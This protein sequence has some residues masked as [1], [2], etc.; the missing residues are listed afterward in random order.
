MNSLMEP[1]APRVCTRETSQPTVPLDSL[2]LRILRL[3]EILSQK[4]HFKYQKEFGYRFVEAV[5]LHD[6]DML[7]ALWA[8]QSGK[9]QL[10]ADILAACCLI[11]PLLARMKIFEDDWRLNCTDE[12]GNYRGYKYGVVVGIYAPKQ[13][14][15]DIVY[16][17]LR[18]TLETDTTKEVAAE[19]N[20]ALDIGNANKTRLSN[21]SR[22]R[23]Q[24]ASEQSHIEGDTYHILILDEAQDIGT[25]KVRKCFAEGTL[26]ITSGG[27]EVPVEEVVKKKLPVLTP[28][29]F[30]ESRDIEYHDNGV[31]PV[32]RVTL[33]GGRY[34]DVTA[35]HRHFVRSR[36]RRVPFEALTYEIQPGWQM[37]VPTRLNNAAGVLGN[38][39]RG[40][41]LGLLLGD[42]CF[43]GDKPQ[44]I[45]E[46][47][48][49]KL[50]DRIC[51]HEF[52]VRPVVY[53][54]Q[55]SGMLECGLTSP[56]NKKGSNK[57]TE[58][59]KKIGVWGAKRENK[60]IPNLPWSLEFL[61]G[62]AS[63]LIIADG[64]IE[65][66]TVKPVVSFSNCSEY[67][68]DGLRKT[69]L[70]FG[71]QCAKFEGFVESTGN[72][73]GIK[74]RLGTYMYR[75]HIKSV[76]D[77]REFHKQFNLGPKQDALEAGIRTIQGKRGRS[78]SQFYPED[79]QFVSVKSVRHIGK[80]PTYCVTVPDER[81][82]V[83]ANGIVTGNS[84]H[85]MVAAY[86]GVI[87]KIGTCSTEK[88]DFYTSIKSNQRLYAQGEA[89][90][91][92]RYDYLVCQ[93]YNSMYR[94]YI[95]KEKVR[96][97]EDS[98]EFRL[99]YCCEWLLERGQFITDKQL[100]TPAIA[101]THGGYHEIWHRSSRVTT[102][103][104]GIDFGKI[105]DPSVITVMDVDWRTPVADEWV[106]T[107][108][109]S[110]HWI[111]YNKRVVAWHMLLGD[112]YEHQFHEIVNF[113]SNFK[114]L[115]KITLDA[116][117]V[118]EWGLDKFTVYYSEF[119]RGKGADGTPEMGFVE[120]QGVKFTPASKSDGF[121]ILHSDLMSGR[122]SFPAGEKA[123]K[124]RHFRRFVGE[125]LDL[126]K[127]YKNN[128][129][130][131]E[132]P[133]EP[134][135]HDD[136]PV[137]LMLAAYGAQEPAD[138]GEIEVQQNFMVG[139]GVIA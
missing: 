10:I 100:M 74:E 57:L 109:G 118:G 54:E 45:V 127:L 38:F 86:N 33:A 69:L 110:F 8:R 51:P 129:M 40:F 58:W 135:A 122:L 72:L 116:T 107:P 16:S 59:L 7:T 75:L 101:K 79:I 81:H 78:R 5:L 128:Y 137:S 61:R 35:N 117:G 41:L 92:Y 44:I 46:P 6:G 114:G 94:D 119:D 90:N 139:A 29:G 93:K 30:F 87:V 70:H 112:N 106:D 34:L 99:S 111:A 55:S 96:L 103:I 76:E 132:H 85:P 15:A 28:S 130:V 121:K 60:R 105:H 32:Y 22:I 123:R 64:S 68:V 37:A 73:P 63:G 39:D 115:R 91:H 20:V 18:D 19:L 67:L 25:L 131:C 56:G 71:I 12:Q 138:T 2:V 82:F 31:Q 97:G 23:S 113:L 134:G 13:E 24:S 136:Y 1:M 98:D 124:S 133:D 11:L 21:G 53:N 104:A 26:F 52:G 47:S 50:L 108:E 65:N 49:K 84:L 14:Q 80:K 48:V 36:T 27:I 77:V 17:R 62:L 125:M 83:I 42:G 4:R 3:A 66:P 43:T 95:K 89:K 126:R 88:S 9:S 102:Q 120:V